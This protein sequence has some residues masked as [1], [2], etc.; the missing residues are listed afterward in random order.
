MIGSI[1]NPDDNIAT[2]LRSKST[3]IATRV[4]SA[5]GSDLIV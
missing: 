4:I 2:H 3:N 5:T 1:S